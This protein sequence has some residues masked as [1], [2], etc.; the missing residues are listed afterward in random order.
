MLVLFIYILV[1]H[2]AYAGG[3]VTA[4]VHADFKNESLTRG[5][6]YIANTLLFFLFVVITGPFVHIAA[7]A[8]KQNL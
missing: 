1:L 6:I 2:I 4:M 5:F 8:Y 3:T 7:A